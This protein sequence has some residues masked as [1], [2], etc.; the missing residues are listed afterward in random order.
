MQTDS[1]TITTLWK[2][3]QSRVCHSKK[4][5]EAAEGEG[6]APYNPIDH[7]Y[8]RAIYNGEFSRIVVNAIEEKKYLAQG[9]S[10][11]ASVNNG[12]IPDQVEAPAA[13]TFNEGPGSVIEN[14][15]AQVMDLSARV[16]KLEKA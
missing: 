10:R 13:L 16:A 4:E 1:M 3:G 14:L 9:W 2:D 8:P 6:F 11:T 7:Q 5:V 15:A 12:V